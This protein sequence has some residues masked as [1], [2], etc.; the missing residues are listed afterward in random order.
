MTTLSIL[1]ALA[2]AAVVQTSDG[3]SHSTRP[4]DTVMQ[5]Q[6]A[7]RSAP[8]AQRPEEA[9]RIYDAYLNSIGQKTKSKSDTPAANAGDQS[10]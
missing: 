2:S 9:R 1:A 10:R 5:A 4:Y 7:A 3:V 8:V 6:Y